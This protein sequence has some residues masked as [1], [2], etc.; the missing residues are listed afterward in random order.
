MLNIFKKL[1]KRKI[2]EGQ[3][4]NNNYDNLIKI[5]INNK[6]GCFMWKNMVTDSK[7]NMLSLSVLNCKL[8][9]S[10]HKMSNDELDT[11]IN[12]CNK[13]P[14]NAILS[15]AVNETSYIK[16]NE[17]ATSKK[18]YSWNPKLIINMLSLMIFLQ[19]CFIC[20]KF[21]SGD[22]RDHNSY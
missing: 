8:N 2:H 3:L 12:Y 5:Y 9:E 13:E 16:I 19:I 15:T 10:K 21:I 1:Y 11:I 22:V 17:V 18:C 6:Y 7:Y 14:I 4:H 20:S